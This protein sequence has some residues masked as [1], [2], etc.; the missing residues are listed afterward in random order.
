MM[1][2][3]INIYLLPV[4][5]QLE[6]SKLKLF[7]FI[8]LVD[9]IFLIKKENKNEYHI[10]FS[11]TKQIGTNFIRNAAAARMPVSRLSTLNN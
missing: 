5:K 7:G 10:T 1:I 3:C 11:K 2:C 9:F 4:A 6:S 8:F